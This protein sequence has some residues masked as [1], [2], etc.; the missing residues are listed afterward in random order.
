MTGVVLLFFPFTALPFLYVAMAMQK[1]NS[2]VKENKQ[3][4]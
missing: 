4:L 1:N 2:V 3:Q